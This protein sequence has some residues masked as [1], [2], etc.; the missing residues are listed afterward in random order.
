MPPITLAFVFSDADWPTLNFG[1]AIC[2]GWGSIMQWPTGS[3]TNEELSEKAPFVKSNTHW[4]GIFFV[5]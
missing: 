4:F 2:T 5:H 1:F 3:K